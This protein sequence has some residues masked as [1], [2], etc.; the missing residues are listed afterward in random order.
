MARC[1]MVAQ[2]RSSFSSKY[3]RYRSRSYDDSHNVPSST[4]VTHEGT[5]NE[6]Y[7]KLKKKETKLISNFEISYASIKN[8]ITQKREYFLGLLGKSKYDGIGLREPIDIGI[9][10][11]ISG[12]MSDNMNKKNESRLDVAKKSLITFINNLS[13]NDNISITAF[14]H[15]CINIISFAN[16]KK[17]LTNKKNID[18]I[19]ALIPDGGTDIYKGLK[20]VYDN[21]K[22]NKKNINKQRRIILITDMEYYGNSDF[23]NLIKEMAENNIFLTILGISE[24]FNTGLTELISKE[25]G[26]NYYVILN[27]T[28][29]KKYLI[30]EF[31]YICFPLS[32]N[33]KLEILS[34]FLKVKSIIGTGFKS[35]E[36]KKEN[37]EW[38]LDTHK[39]FDKEFKDNI[40]FLLLYFKRK[41][42]ILPKPVI[43]C[44]SQFLKTFHR[45]TIS[46]INTTFPSDLTKYK[47]DFYVKGGMILIKLDE[48]YVKED[49]V[50][51][52]TLSGED[53]NNQK[54]EKDEVFSFK[55]KENDYFSDQNIEVSLALY[56]FTK[57]N[58]KIMKICNKE[59]KNKK[60]NSLNFIAND[61]FSEIKNN[62]TK[63]LKNH[64]SKKT[65]NDNMDK[66]LTN[67]N[68]ICK[69]AVDYAKKK[70]KKSKT[71]KNEI[72]LN[73]EEEEKK[74]NKRKKTQKKKKPAAKKKLIGNKR[75]RAK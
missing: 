28:D 36:E 20:K 30:D 71:K 16:A 65:I 17:F 53:T 50:C 10:L 61:K 51:Q 6:N 48:N 60:N 47:K 8:P 54:Y 56:Y 35:L 13:E 67:M 2:A 26:C 62:I 21:M 46:E 45:K 44:I 69:E 64:Y 31:N 70:T 9:V 24:S 43:L 39:L 34:P 1:K 3:V 4:T 58:R 15:E 40:F 37:V 27:D 59:Y 14:N 42:K 68:N 5:I 7:Y 32:F 57:F 72:E 49:N 66:Y 73:E 52:F 12:S 63:L 41:G 55:K 11:D 33:E 25:K 75:K 74:S 23:V 29:M 18:K 19:K 38:H 22:N